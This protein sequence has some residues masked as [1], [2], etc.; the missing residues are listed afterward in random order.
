MMLYSKRNH[1]ADAIELKEK[2]EGREYTIDIYTDGS[3]SSSGVGSGIEVFVNK[4]LTLQ[5]KYKLAEECS[6]NQAEQLAIVKALE[7]LLDCSYTH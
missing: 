1:L 5:I 4:Y 3:K 6:K 2:C 7:K